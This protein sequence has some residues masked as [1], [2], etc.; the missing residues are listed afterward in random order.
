LGNL[1]VAREGLPIGSFYGWEMVGVNPETGMI[2][3]TRADGTVGP[4]DFASDKKIIGNPNPDFFGGITNTFSYK[5]FDLSIMGQY[6]YGNDIFNY[7]LFTI[8]SGSGDS[9]NGSADWN[10]RWRNPGDVT[11][12]PRPT[13]A[14]LDNGTVSNRFVEDGSFFRIRN[15]TLG[16]TLPTTVLEKLKLKSLRIYATVQNA[17]VFTNYRGYDPEVSSSPGG[18]NTGLVY[19]FDYGSYPQPRIFTGGVNLTF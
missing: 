9:N 5:G 15:I 10:R 19:G 4:P 17:Y 12:V 1:N 13:P 16:Y 3:F 8:L 6:S 7:N 18:A 2:D 14:D 11:D